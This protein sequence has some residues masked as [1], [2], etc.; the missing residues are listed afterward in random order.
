MKGDFLVQVHI[1]G[2]DIAA[3]LGITDNLLE[4]F[5]KGALQGVSILANGQA[6]DYAI[7]QINARANLKVAV[8]LNLTE[9]QA[10]L[11]PDT[12]PLLTD[13]RGFF[14]LSFARLLLA[15]LTP[16][17]RQQLKNQ[18]QAEWQA[19]IDKVRTALGPERPLRIDSHQHVHAVPLLTE[20]IVEF[21][22]TYNFRH[23]RLPLEPFFFVPSDFKNYFSANIVK[24]FLLKV[25]SYS[26][27]RR[28]TLAEIP[29]N[30]QLVGIL[31]SGRMQSEVVRQALRR[32]RQG[33]VEILFHPGGARRGEEAIW[34]TQA[35]FA[36]F[37]FDVGR[38]K[39]KQAL[40][41]P[42]L[43]QMIDELI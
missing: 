36:S 30:S 41:Q 37:Y 11:S 9:G 22:Q 28:L 17:K 1:H 24:H 13:S 21:H 29:Y 10:V 3:S 14:C 23:V 6:F 27:R 26:M 15:S 40:L 20:I 16:K 19:Q 43:Q 39:E 31:F 5:D 42:S 12:V 2:D 8:H 38:D 32:I 33:S 4:T 25:L 18:I 7:A 35:Q 34:Q